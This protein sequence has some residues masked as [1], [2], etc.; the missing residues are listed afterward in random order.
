LL[1]NLLHA[2]EGE[3]ATTHTFDLNMAM[4]ID[5]GPKDFCKIA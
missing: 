4:G 3:Q 2:D 1:Q 5:C